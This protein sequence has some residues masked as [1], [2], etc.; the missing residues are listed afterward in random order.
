MYRNDIVWSMGP[1]L[2]WSCIKTSLLDAPKVKNGKWKAYEGRKKIVQPWNSHQCQW[3]PYPPAN[4]APQTC[5]FPT[6]VRGDKR[7]QLRPILNGGLGCY[8]YG[9][10]E[11]ASISHLH[12]K[13]PGL[14]ELLNQIS[15]FIQID[16]IAPMD[17]TL[18]GARFRRPTKT[19]TV[20]G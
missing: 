19:N 10:Y 15:G 2:H 16:K 11:Q 6:L 5:W 13:L 4:H 8:M 7:G 9:L 1:F 20:F 3:T 17:Q 18:H 14:N 12:S